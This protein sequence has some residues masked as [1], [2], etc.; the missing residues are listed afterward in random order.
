MTAD[1]TQIRLLTYQYADASNLGARMR[2]HQRYRT[3]PQPWS[4]WAFEQM[5]L[6]PG[7]R[8]LELGAG[9]GTL[10]SVNAGSVPTGEIVLTDLSLGMLATA[11]RSIA[12]ARAA[13]IFAAVDAQAIPFRD[14]SFDVVIANHMLYH[15]PDRQ[16]A[17]GE[18][19]RVLRDGGRF[20]AAANGRDYLLEI[21]E[22]A[23]RFV[24]G[25][26]MAAHVERFGLETGEEQLRSRF[27]DVRLLRYA[28]ELAITEAQPVVDYVASM[29]RQSQAPE[30]SLAAL[31]SEV[32]AIIAR[33][34]VL[35]VRKGS[36][37]FVAR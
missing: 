6:Q 35:R 8:V 17:I 5:H 30:S 10:W 29:S 19:R 11:R 2:L 34:G 3:N 37:M 21:D 23:E 26:R 7:E 4:R 9:P 36:G 15:V 18:I 28:D 32:E 20:F 24:P 13:W 14:G 1:E 22:L 31:R 16:R 33:D 25:V 12:A 27:A